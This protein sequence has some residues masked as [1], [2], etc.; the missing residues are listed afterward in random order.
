[1]GCFRFCHTCIVDWPVAMLHQYGLKYI[2][3]EGVKDS[4]ANVYTNYWH[5][6][7]VN[8]QYNN[9]T[10]HPNG[11]ITMSWDKMLSSSYMLISQPEVAL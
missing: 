1:M 6:H 4:S 7:I 3:H 9:L 8:S 10:W 5:I 11:I 2:W